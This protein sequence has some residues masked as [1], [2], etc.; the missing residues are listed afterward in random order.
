MVA[1]PKAW[2]C[3]RSLAMI[4]GFETRRGFGCLSFLN[5]VFGQVVF[6]LRRADPSYRGFLP[7]VCVCDHKALITRKPRPSRGLRYGENKK[8]IVPTIDF[9]LHFQEFDL[10]PFSFA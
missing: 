1:R 4:R 6:S 7:R 9:S 3:G 5:A 2:V 10:L 8:K